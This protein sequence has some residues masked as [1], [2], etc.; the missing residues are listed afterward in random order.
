MGGDCDLRMRRARIL[1]AIALASV[2][3]GCG[4]SISDGAGLRADP[5]PA[6]VVTPCAHP[7]ALLGRG[8]T[9]ADDEISLGRIGDAL[10]LCEGRRGAAVRAYNGIAAAIASDEKGDI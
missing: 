1:T 2:L 5:L 7:S 8:G 9:V 10:I 3:T 4:A 6:A